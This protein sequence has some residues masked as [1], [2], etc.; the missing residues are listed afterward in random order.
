MGALRLER[1]YQHARP[2]ALVSAVATLLAALFVCLGGGP[3]GS[4]GHPGHGG[5]SAT[6]LT[7]PAGPAATPVSEPAAYVCPYD[8]GDCSLFPSLSPAVLSAPPLDPPLHA[9]GR[10]PRGDAR[11][12]EGA[13]GD[14]GTRPRAPDLHVL[15]VLR[16]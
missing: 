4:G 6:A 8:R 12:G 2:L 7:A 11:A 9:E 3:G 14:P 1:P 13:T 5:G 15:Q 16:T 10:P